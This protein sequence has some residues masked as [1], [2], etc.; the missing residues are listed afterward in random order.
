MSA[1]QDCQ[2]CPRLV[3]SRR[4]VVNSRGIGR[5]VY[6]CGQNPGQE[7]DEQGKCFVGRSGH[8]LASLA[9]LAGLSLQDATVGNAV[10]CHSPGNS[11]PKKEEIAACRTY[12]EDEIREIQPDLI[13]ALGA[14]ALESLYG[15]VPLGTVA[16]QTLY[17]QDG[18][19]AEGV[20][21]IPLLA[22]YHPAAILRNWALAPLV[23]THFEKAARILNGTQPEEGLG[24]Y[25]TIKTIPELETLRDYLAECDVVTLDTE[26]VGTEWKDDELLCISF[27]GEPGEGFVVPILG[28]GIQSLD[29]WEGKYP[30]VIRIVGEILSSPVPKGL[31]N[32]PFDMRFLERSSDQPFITAATAFGWHVKNLHH[33]TMQY[34]KV[35]HEEMP[36]ESK[37][38]ELTRL[39]AIYT[40]VPYYEEDVRIQSKNK[41]RMDLVDNDVNWSYAAADADIVQRLIPPLRA[42]VEE[43]GMGWVMDNITIPM[44]RVCQNMTVRGILVDRPYFDR[45]SKYYA[46]QIR[47][48]ERELYTYAGEF[49][50]NSPQQV[51]DVMFN[52]LGLPKTG[53]KTGAARE[54]VDCAAGTCEKHEQ[55]GKDALTELVNTTGHPFVSCLKRY[56]ELSKIRGTYLDGSDK[57]TDGG[58]VQ[59][60]RTDR[61]IHSEFKVGGAESGRLA[62]VS[63]NTQNLPK[64]IKIEEWGE[65]EAFRSC[66]VAPDGYVLMEADWSQL[67]VYVNCY[68]AGD[69]DFLDVLHS[70]VDVHT[71]VG[72]KIP[73][74]GHPFPL[75]PELND[76]EWK[77]TH[78]GLRRKAKDLVFGSQYALTVAGVMERWNCDETEAQRMLD[79]YFDLRPRLRDYI[80]QIRQKVLSGETLV[81]PFGRRF[82]FPQ[83]PLLKSAQAGAGK[84]LYHIC[85][86]EMEA[87]VREGINRPTQATGS[88]LHSLSHIWTEHTPILEGRMR[89][90]LAVHDSV[91]GEAS[92]PAQ[93]FVIDTA[94]KVKEHWQRIAKDTR[95]PDGSLLGYE[96]PVD[97]KWGRTWG[98]MHNKLTPRGD[99][100]LED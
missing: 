17:W 73:W 31:Q 20:V 25:K 40:G 3:A 4:C 16:G 1:P 91:I 92:A 61:R 66:F 86:T 68:L 83:I 63:P 95:L 26:T 94:W 43:E 64:E 54:C 11:A 81:T 65:E 50:P 41:T 70:G 37:P 9:K 88:D 24:R 32:A 46:E 39:T 67:E 76:S 5:R 45:L 82:H 59:H 48:T 51:Q 72:R 85:R 15:K 21:P 74:S 52:R 98:R 97:L 90:N 58:F 33:D 28:Q 19:L 6:I 79:L 44:I 23:L 27:S 12:L 35:L 53:R 8:V 78:D 99:V 22:T 18:E 84:T 30:D 29:F 93:D 56:R 38:N 71:Y 47:E 80:D 14:T 75:D 36:K 7:E 42:E 10:R 87:V 13:V 49:N 96:I 34:H 57:N 2:R 62:S 60:I 55:T 100:I 89:P 69:K 77:S